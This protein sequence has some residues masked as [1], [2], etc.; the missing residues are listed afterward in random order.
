MLASSQIYHLR[1]SSPQLKEGTPNKKD[2]RDGRL[3][4]M[5]Q[6]SY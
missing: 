2:A 3:A 6:K 1:R 5:K 4:M